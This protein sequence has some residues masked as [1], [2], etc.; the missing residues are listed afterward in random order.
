[1][2]KVEDFLKK[3]KPNGNASAKRKLEKGKSCSN[4]NPEPEEE[5]VLNNW[6]I[7]LDKCE[8]ERDSLTAISS[9]SVKTPVC[10]LVLY[11]IVLLIFR[12]TNRHL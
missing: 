9:T 8:F 3:S 5:N 7:L 6:I 1:M 2:K 10:C 4:N 12:N 11:R